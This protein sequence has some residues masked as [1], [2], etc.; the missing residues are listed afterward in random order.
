MMHPF[1]IVAE[2]VRRRIIEVLAVGEHPVGILNDV[3]AMEFSISRSAVS[4]HLRI[5]RDEGVVSVAP[6]QGLP[7]SRLY[8]VNGEYLE[9]LDDAV[10]E[11]FTLWEQRYGTGVRRAPQFPAHP[12]SPTRQPHMHRAGRRGQRGRRDGRRSE[13][14]ESDHLSTD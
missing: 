4:H 12:A 6:D 14:P 3:I 8:V 11:L 13:P 1:E 10:G 2:P 7:Q 5:L 9:R